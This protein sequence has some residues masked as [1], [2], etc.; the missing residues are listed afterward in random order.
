MSGTVA[1]PVVDGADMRLDELVAGA[2]GLLQGVAARVRAAFALVDRAA[3]GS[4]QP[5]WL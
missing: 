5:T 1:G 4:S 2:E 3:P